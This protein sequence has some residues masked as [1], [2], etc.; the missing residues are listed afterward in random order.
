MLQQRP[1]ADL[2]DYLFTKAIAAYHL[3][4]TLVT[5]GHESNRFP[6][7]GDAIHY[8]FSTGP[9][10]YGEISAAFGYSASPSQNTCVL[11]SIDLPST[12]GRGEEPPACARPRGW[13]GDLVARTQTLE[14]LGDTAAAL[15]L[16]YD[17]VDDLMHSQQFAL[18]ACYLLEVE[19]TSCSVDVLLAL[20]T[21]T[22]PAK[23]K[24]GARTEFAR[25]VESELIGRGEDAAELLAGLT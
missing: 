22:L 5:I 17:C 13:H 1:P 9:G 14:R 11:C 19:V 23:Q 16:V 6:Q 12:T 24:I 7:E 2:A 21:A 4:D 3:G 15:D 20:L 10:L 8:T 25:R 18:M